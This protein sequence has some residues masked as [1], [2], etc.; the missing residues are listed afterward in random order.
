MSEPAWVTEWK[1][2]EHTPSKPVSDE[3]AKK[4]DGTIPENKSAKAK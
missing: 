3:M 1:K 4:M 2:G